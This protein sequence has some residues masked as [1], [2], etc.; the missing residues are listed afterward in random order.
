MIHDE[1]NCPIGAVEYNDQEN[2]YPLCLCYNQKSKYCRKYQHEKK[3]CNCHFEERIIER[4]FG[5]VKCPAPNCM[6]EGEYSYCSHNYIRKF[7]RANI[8]RYNCSPPGLSA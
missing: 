1:I 4:N 7:L 8:S 5:G 3:K 2:K 6:Y